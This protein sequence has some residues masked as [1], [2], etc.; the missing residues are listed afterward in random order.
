MQQIDVQHIHTDI[1]PYTM[2]Q[3]VQYVNDLG[4]TGGDALKVK[5]TCNGEDITIVI[6]QNEWNDTPVCFVGGYGQVLKTVETEKVLEDLPG[7]L[8]YYFDK[9]TSLTVERLN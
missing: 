7:V 4:N 3:L 5:G 8:D 6:N 1:I 2:Q 9:N